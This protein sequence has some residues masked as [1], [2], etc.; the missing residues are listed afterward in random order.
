[1]LDDESQSRSLVSDA[2]RNEVAAMKIENKYVWKDTSKE[3]TTDSETDSV[4][5]EKK[6]K[7]KTDKEEKFPK[8]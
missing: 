7:T 3:A 4:K 5:K 2:V 1:M 8:V 6:K